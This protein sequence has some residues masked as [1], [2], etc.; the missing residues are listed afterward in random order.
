MKNMDDGRIEHQQ[1]PVSNDH[2][3]CDAQTTSSMAS[4]W[5]LNACPVGDAITRIVSGWREHCAGQS[6]ALKRNQSKQH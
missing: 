1:Q 3:S 4:A 6:N 2:N 5:L